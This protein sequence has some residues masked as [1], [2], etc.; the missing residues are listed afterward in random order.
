MRLLEG[1]RFVM[2][3]L[4]WLAAG[5]GNDP[6]Y[7]LSPIAYRCELRGE[8]LRITSWVDG[9]IRASSREPPADEPIELPHDPAAAHRGQPK[10]TALYDP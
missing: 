6:G 3:Q 1:S 10:E 4:Y 9:K 8:N 7:C 5:G 2:S